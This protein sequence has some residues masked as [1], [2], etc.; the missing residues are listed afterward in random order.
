[1]L[2]VSER[3]EPLDLMWD[4]KIAM[5]RAKALVDELRAV[6]ELEAQ[7]LRADRIHYK[8]KASS[9]APVRTRH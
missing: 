4:Q 7:I 5:Q 2:H 9:E 6:C 3:E 1:M 8:E